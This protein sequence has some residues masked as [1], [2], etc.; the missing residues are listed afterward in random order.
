MTFTLH[1]RDEADGTPPYNIPVLLELDNGEH[2]VAIWR[3]RRDPSNDEWESN[4]RHVPQRVL[5]WAY[6]PSG[7]PDKDRH[8]AERNIQTQVNKLTQQATKAFAD[9]IKPAIEAALQAA[10]TRTPADDD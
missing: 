3:W 5:R 4:G 6:L 1:F 9:Q 2:L 7:D 10:L 8:R